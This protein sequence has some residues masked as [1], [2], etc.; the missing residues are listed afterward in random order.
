MKV[1]KNLQ[2]ITIILTLQSY[3]IYTRCS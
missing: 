2:T 1:T 3:T